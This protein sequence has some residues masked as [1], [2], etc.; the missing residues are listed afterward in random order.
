MEAKDLPPQLRLTL[1]SGTIFYFAHRGLSSS[2]SHYFVVLNASPL[3]SQL[4][5]LAVAS[6]QVDKVIKRRAGFPPET[7]VIVDPAEF[8]EFTRRTVI[9]CNQVFELSR[10]ELVQKFVS[11]ELRHHMDLPTTILERVWHGVHTSPRVD[12]IHKQLL[13][14]D[15]SRGC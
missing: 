3:S 15:D 10:D 7:L 13:P 2:E 14:P 9:D 11:K 12:E 4:L 6:S 1:R 8:K 5:V